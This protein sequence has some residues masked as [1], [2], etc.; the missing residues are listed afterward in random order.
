MKK[1]HFISQSGIGKNGTVACGF[2][3]IK[4]YYFDYPKRFINRINEVYDFSIKYRYNP[5]LVYCRE[6][7]PGTVSLTRGRT[8]GDDSKHDSH[9]IAIFY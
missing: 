4:V 7:A 3:P 6:L 9:Y 2:G 5:F 8:Q 1:F